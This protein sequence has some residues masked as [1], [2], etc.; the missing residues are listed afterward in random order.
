VT[1]WTRLSPGF[2]VAIFSVVLGG[3]TGCG[4]AP[5]STLPDTTLLDS[6]GDG[7][8]DEVEANGAPGT[9]PFDPTDNPNNVRDTD[10]DGCSD[11]DE[12][13][14]DGFCDN[15]PETTPQDTLTLSGVYGQSVLEL[16]DG[17]VRTV[18]LPC[19]AAGWNIGDAV[20]IDDTGLITNLD[21]G[22]I[23]GSAYL[24]SAVAHTFVQEVYAAGQFVE[25]SNPTWTAW[26]IGN[27]TYQGWVSTWPIGQPIVIV[28]GPF[29]F[30]D[31][32]QP[33]YLVRQES[34][35][36]IT[37]HYVKATPLQ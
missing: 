25:L 26:E 35:C 13:H 14:F 18:S 4:T 24:G 6:D 7:F 29:S 10:G 28:V 23:T 37:G 36:P 15:D 22:E 34:T 16:S 12:L 1:I 21:S 2:V 19:P 31:S 3:S 27:A 17:A 20:A 5:G 11:Y 33:F 30:P 9:D 32:E 8:P